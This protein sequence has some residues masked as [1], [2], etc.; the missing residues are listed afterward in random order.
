[1]RPNRLPA[2]VCTLWLAGCG[3]SVTVSPTAASDVPDA[4]APRDVPAPRDNPTTP[5]DVVV[6]PVDVPP[7]PVDAGPPATNLPLGAAC[8]RDAEC[9][10]HVC[11]QTPGIVSGCAQP[12]TRDA[13]CLAV[14]PNDAC[15]LDRAPGGGRFV[16][17]LVAPAMVDRG[18]ACTGDGDCISGFCLESVC[19]NACATD[20]ECLAGWHCGAQPVGA[21]SV[22]A[23]R[24][25]PIT[26]V[27][28][29]TYTLGEGNYV[30]QRPTNPW[31]VVA[32]PDTVSLTWVTQ[33][34]T[35]ADLYAAASTITDPNAR[36]LVDLRTWNTL[37]EQPVREI[38]A[39]LQVNVSTF[40][41]R[42]MEPMVPGM[43]QS[44]HVLLNAA[45]GMAAATHRLRASVLVKRAPGGVA[46]AGWAI[47]VQ[48]IVVGLPGLS[49]ATIGSTARM[50]AA[51]AR[52]QQIYGAAGVVVN[53]RGFSDATDAARL[54]TIDTQDEFHALLQQSAGLPDGV[55]PV[56]LVQSIADTAGLEGAVGV[57]GA[58]DGPPGIQGTVQSGVVAG[59]SSTLAGAN[60]ILGQVLAHE[61][62]HFLGLWHTR[63][64]LPACTTAGQ[65]MCSIWGGVDNVTDTPAGP[66]A[67]NYLMYWS[68]DGRNTALS[69]GE[70]LMMRLNPL[71]R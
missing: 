51:I 63:E 17:G 26:G 68:T 54:T 20:A 23:C 44:S 66:T 60:D 42:D 45:T 36:T 40:P 33:D 27:T 58:I 10:S 71:V 43:F 3:A 22:Q 57:A 9:A 64:N 6:A 35:G 70:A 53:I 59:W 4:G 56:F 11:A 41:G 38:P 47:S 8:A 2:A 55:L 62:G 65:M 48:F 37:H 67:A 29:E 34:L 1:M 19:H 50:R 31:S 25:N 18:G 61:C 13:D 32:P 14:N 49:A 30:T 52:M 15:V 24:A 12:C 39:R 21:A 16:C 5:A 7:P 28:V 69:A 46:A